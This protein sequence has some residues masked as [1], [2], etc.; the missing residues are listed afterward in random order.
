MQLIQQAFKVEVIKP[1][2]K[3]TLLD[4]A[5]LANYRANSELPE[6]SLTS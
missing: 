1:L 6:N 5:V 3:K 2:V 4:P